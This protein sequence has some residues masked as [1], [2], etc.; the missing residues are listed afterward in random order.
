[1]VQ[2]FKKPDIFN[3]ILQVIRFQENACL[4]SVATS[5]LFMTMPLLS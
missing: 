4:P 5:I 2:D 1:M 3:L